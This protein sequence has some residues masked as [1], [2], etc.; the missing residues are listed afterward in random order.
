M[1][2]YGAACDRTSTSAPRRMTEEETKAWSFGK[3]ATDS[4]NF[5]G[6]KKAILKL[7]EYSKICTQEFKVKVDQVF[8]K[9][10]EM[11]RVRDEECKKGGCPRRH[12][13]PKVVEF[14]LP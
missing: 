12:H 5:A 8:S 9:F 13:Q 3:I 4:A 1:G 11:S 7:C 14:T 10:D 6:W 2:K